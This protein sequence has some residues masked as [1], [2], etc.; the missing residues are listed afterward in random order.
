MAQAVSES[1]VDFLAPDKKNS[2]KECALYVTYITDLIER[3][4]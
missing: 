1:G 3:K 2:K 4:F